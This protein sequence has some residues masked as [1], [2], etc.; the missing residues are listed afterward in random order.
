MQG[1]ADQKNGVSRGKQP[2]AFEDGNWVCDD[3][4]CNNVNYPR[5]TECNK[6]KKK[7][8][9]AGDTVV[10][11]YLD[12]LNVSRVEILKPLAMGHSMVMT[13]EHMAMSKGMFPH[14]AFKFPH[15]KPQSVHPHFTF[16][17]NQWIG[18]GFEHIPPFPPQYIGGNRSIPGCS[19]MPRIPSDRE[20]KHLAEHLVASFAASADPF[21]N[22]WEC[23][24][25]AAAWLQNMRARGQNVECQIPTPSE[26]TDSDTVGGLR[27]IINLQ[28]PEKIG[29]FMPPRIPLEVQ[30]TNEWCEDITDSSDEFLEGNPWFLPE[31]L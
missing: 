21:S 26:V 27:G 25:S 4:H 3:S 20:G 10:K 2:R 23:L 17:F 1:A 11:A 31:F 15:Q 24:S 8:G 30:Q 14:K 6:C 12:S 5:R 28:S 7:R 9:P 13:E 18:T 19:F 29:N 22:A 16:D